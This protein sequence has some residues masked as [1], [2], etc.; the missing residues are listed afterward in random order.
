MN[1]L[2]PIQL[3]EIL[4]SHLE[5]KI[6]D[7]NKALNFTGD[8]EQEMKIRTAASFD[9]SP[10]IDVGIKATVCPKK[11]HESEE[12]CFIVS[13]DLTGLFLI[14]LQRF[15]TE[16]LKDWVKINAPYLLL[17]YVREHVYGVASR[18]GIRGLMLPLLIQP[19]VI[20]RS[21]ENN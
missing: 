8:V 4:I 3:K 15:N 16:D 2:H 11:V 10:E 13:V 1:N 5:I 19:R 14:D 9:E 20:P 18:A 21:S 6:F 12:P 17:P 7:H